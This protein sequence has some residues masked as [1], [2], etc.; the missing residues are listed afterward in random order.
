MVL[1]LY[2]L[3]ERRVMTAM[4]P[5]GL[6]AAVMAFLPAGVGIA[7]TERFP[8]CVRSPLRERGVSGGTLQKPLHQNPVRP[9]PSVGQGP[10]REA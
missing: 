5:R 2:D 7:G 1:V 4:L 6:A 8:L 3:A 9:A 10:L